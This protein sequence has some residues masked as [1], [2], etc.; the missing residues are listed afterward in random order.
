M[1]A[2]NTA[3]FVEPDATY[4]NR[5]C[6]RGHV[7]TGLRWLNCKSRKPYVAR[8]KWTAS[9]SARHRCSDGRTSTR[10]CSR[11]SAPDRAGAGTAR[12]HSCS[13]RGLEH[14]RPRSGHGP[15]LRH[16]DGQLL[17]GARAGYLSGAARSSLPILAPIPELSRRCF[18]WVS[19]ANN[20]LFAITG[21][22][23]SDVTDPANVSPVT[24]IGS[25]TAG[26]WRAATM[27]GHGILVNGTDEPLTD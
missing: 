20:K 14:A 3:W 7:S 10:H 25:V 4:R 19:G 12:G 8:P 22:T 5:F 2:N 11:S 13:C 27:N 26:R 6:P 18:N 9:T 21:T 1:Y 17:S 24:G 16:A 23:L 15:Q